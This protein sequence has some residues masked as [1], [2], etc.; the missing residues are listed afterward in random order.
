MTARRNLVGER[1]RVARERA[2]PPLTQAELSARL[3]AEGVSVGRVP[4]SKIE[5]G[6]R[7]VTDIELVALVKVLRVSPSWLL[8]IEG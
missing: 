7:A 1:V 8:G 6:T 4:I 2:R 3:Q 5:N